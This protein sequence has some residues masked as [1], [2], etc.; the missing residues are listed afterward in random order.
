[1]LGRAAIAGD[2]LAGIVTLDGGIWQD[3]HPMPEREPVAS[4]DG[5]QLPADVVIA[6]V[7]E[8]MIAEMH[9]IHG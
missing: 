3:D 6:V 7:R 4:E 2:A 1:L 5:G 9:L 8:R